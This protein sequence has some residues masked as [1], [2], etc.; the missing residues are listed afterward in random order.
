[1]SR[2]QVGSDPLFSECMGL[3]RYHLKQAAASLSVSLERQCG[4]STEQTDWL[5]KSTTVSLQLYDVNRAVAYDIYRYAKFHNVGT[6]DEVRIT[7]ISLS[8]IA[9]Y[10][11]KWIVQL[12]PFNI[13]HLIDDTFVPA[14]IHE[15]DFDSQV[16]KDR[17]LKNRRF[18]L[19]NEHYAIHV[20]DR[21]LALTLDEKPA[22]ILQF[23]EQKEAETFL[24]ALRYRLKF[25]DVF[26]PLLSHLYHKHSQLRLVRRPFS[27]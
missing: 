6:W 22:S 9:A 10:L 17:F 2:V 15:G 16:Q 1:M 24:Y 3:I 5:F 7:D 12:R 26:Q 27:N 23:M 14:V 21:V 13:N 25:Q 8:V 18:L 19:V 4:L 20:A 11:I